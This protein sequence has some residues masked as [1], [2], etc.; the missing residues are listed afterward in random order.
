MNYCCIAQHISAMEWLPRLTS[1]GGGVNYFGGRLQSA[2]N[3]GL[4]MEEPIK[5]ETCGCCEEQGIAYPL[6][7]EPDT[8][9]YGC[10]NCGVIW[11]EQHQ[12]GNLQLYIDPSQS[13]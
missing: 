5:L 9:E 4:G 13:L 2:L 8:K 3:E 11:K 10:D 6:W 1:L 7:Y 12:V